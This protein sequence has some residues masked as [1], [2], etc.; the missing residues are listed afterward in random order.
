MR[1]KRQSIRDAETEWHNF[2][3]VGTFTT[4]IFPRSSL[5]LLIF[6]ALIV[7]CASTRRLTS[8]N[9]VPVVTE[10]PRA[11]VNQSLD[12]GKFYT[13]QKGD[14]LYSIALNHGLDYKEL[15]QWNGIDNPSNISTGQKLN[16]FLSIQSAKPSLYPLL[17]SSSPVSSKVISGITPSS[18]SI[19]TTPIT[20]L[21]IE[22][23]AFKVPYS[24]QAAERLRESIDIPSIKTGIDSVTEGPVEVNPPPSSVVLNTNKEVDSIEWIWPTKGKVSGV[25]S[26]STK[27]VDIVGKLG[28]VIIASAAGKVVYSGGGLRGY[29]QL[30]IIKHNNTY[31]SAYA[32]NSKL[33][34]N[35][36]Q[37]VTKGQK[38]AEMGNVSSDL[39]GLHFEIRKLGKPVDPIKHLPDIS[40]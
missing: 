23:K 36:G 3:D 16:L 13:V 7:G 38:I 25:F 34:V 15:A 4:K 26:E 30:I 31:L 9:R 21:K 18:G 32:H 24:E 29:G 37:T 39:V 12:A 35:E 14:T 27:G 1:D 40:G 11:L 17:E 33:L 28:Q 19:V 2:F 8:P 10:R 5:L 6:C 22:P 20:M